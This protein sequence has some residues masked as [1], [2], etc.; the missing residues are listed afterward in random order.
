MKSFVAALTALALGACVSVSV[1]PGVDDVDPTV[2][3]DIPAS[4]AAALLNRYAMPDAAMQLVLHKE[5]VQDGL[6]RQRCEFGETSTRLFSSDE[7]VANTQLRYLV[8]R[9][10]GAASVGQQDGVAFHVRPAGGQRGSGGKM[11]N[12]FLG[13]F[14]GTYPQAERTRELQRLA[15]AAHALGIAKAKSLFDL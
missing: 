11:R 2:V 1:D 10:S 6:A 15:T 4:R 5:R 8:V 14:P 7:T 9:I 3:A 13:F 12:C